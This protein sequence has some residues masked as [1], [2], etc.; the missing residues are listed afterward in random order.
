MTRFFSHNAPDPMTV[1]LC[2]GEAGL[3]DELLPVDTRKIEPSAP[4]FSALN[5]NA[6]LPARC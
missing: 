4:D 1:A 2:L 3:D 6:F 5:P